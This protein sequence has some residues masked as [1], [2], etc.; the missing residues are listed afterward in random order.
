MLH[1]MYV[2]SRVVPVFVNVAHHW[3]LYWKLQ[4]LLLLLPQ[5][6]QVSLIILAR[7]KIIKIIMIEQIVVAI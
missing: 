2:I 6:K 4:V 5:R 7:L 3:H 1:V